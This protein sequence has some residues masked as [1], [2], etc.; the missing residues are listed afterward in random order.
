MTVLDKFRLYLVCILRLDQEGI[1]TLLLQ[2][3]V[4]L[5]FTRMC[6]STKHLRD[7]LTFS[8]FYDPSTA[9]GWKYKL[10]CLLW[11]KVIKMSNPNQLSL[12]F[13]PDMSLLTPLLN[14]A[15]PRLLYKHNPRRSPRLITQV[16]TFTRYNRDTVLHVTL[17]IRLSALISKHRQQL[18]HLASSTLRNKTIA[19]TK[20]SCFTGGPSSSR[21]HIF[22]QLY[23]DL[24]E[25]T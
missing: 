25:L 8:I 24:P 7:T 17:L 2:R 18:Y 14:G 9:N 10:F 15:R 23:L 22:E 16:P 6:V 19:A 12:P 21:S 11:K 20:V 1:V 4:W 5:I 13:A 3:E